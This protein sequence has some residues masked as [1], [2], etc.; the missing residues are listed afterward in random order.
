M[1]YKLFI[2]IISIILTIYAYYSYIISIFKNKTKPHVFSWLIWSISTLVV[3]LWQLIWWGWYWTFW[4]WAI[5]FFVIFIFFI[6]LKKW[7]KNFSKMD[8][9]SLLCAF[10]ALLLWYITNNP[11]YSVILLVSVDIFWFIPTFLKTYK[12]PFSEDIQIYLITGVIYLLSFISLKNYSLLTI[13]WP[14]VIWWVNFIFVFF[15]LF[16]QKIKK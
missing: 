1:D 10:V 14:V 8:I 12:K 13:F 7:E 15:T 9:F 4:S 6:S 16:L 3:F 11:L 2:W 5:A